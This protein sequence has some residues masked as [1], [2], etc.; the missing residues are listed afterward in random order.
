MVKEEKTILEVEKPSPDQNLKNHTH[1]DTKK[2]S[3]NE[4]KR[5]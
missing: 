5:S 2:H 1:A 3:L 4:R